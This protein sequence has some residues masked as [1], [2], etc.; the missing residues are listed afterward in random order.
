MRL[1]D[2]RVEYHC[3]FRGN[4]D[5]APQDRKARAMVVAKDLQAAIRLLS[6]FIGADGSQD[7]VGLDASLID[8]P[9]VIGSTS[10]PGAIYYGRVL[11]WVTP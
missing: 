4:Q 6:K 2:I 1:Y 7:L 10:A 5:T 3:T 8:V 11:D 9:V